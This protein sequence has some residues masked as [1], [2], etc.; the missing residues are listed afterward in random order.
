M[1][2]RFG[3]HARPFVLGFQQE[4]VADAHTIGSAEF[5]EISAVLVL[6]L[7]ED[8]QVLHQLGA[9]ASRV[10]GA[11]GQEARLLFQTGPGVDLISQG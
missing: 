9:G 1:P 11:K 7:I 6:E 8:E 4:C 3:Q 5:D 2:C 10:G